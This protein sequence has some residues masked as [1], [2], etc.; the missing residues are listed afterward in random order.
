MNPNGKVVR[1]AFGPYATR[2]KAQAALKK[3]IRVNT[4]QLGVEMQRVEACVTVLIPD[5]RHD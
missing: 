4:E 5:S 2:A 1:H 3:M